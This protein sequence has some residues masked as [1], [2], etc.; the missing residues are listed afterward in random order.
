[1]NAITA[2]SNIIENI[3]GNSVAEQ[4]LVTVSERESFEE[5]NLNALLRVHDTLG[6]LV[7]SRTFSQPRQLEEYHE[8]LEAYLR[9]QPG[10][11]A[12]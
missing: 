1:M 12:R 8:R 4:F 11:R 9:S 2:T 3:H 7:E 5:Q 10:V 6:D